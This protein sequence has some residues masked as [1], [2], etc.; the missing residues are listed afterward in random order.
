VLTNA[1][2]KNTF[3]HTLHLRVKKILEG[4][5]KAPEWW[6]V[7][8]GAP[9]DADIFDLKVQKAC[10]PA[11]NPRLAASMEIDAREVKQVPSSENEFRRLR[12]GQWVGSS[13]AWVAATIVEKCNLHRIRYD[14]LKG[15]V[16]YGG[17][18]LAYSQ[19]FNA[20][21]LLIPPLKSELV[22]V[23][24]EEQKKDILVRK[25]YPTKKDPFYWLPTFWIPEASV[26]KRKNQE[27]LDVIQWI[28]DG[29]I[30]VTPGFT[31]DDDWIA[32]DILQMHKD[33]DI[34]LNGVDAYRAEGVIKQLIRD[35]M[36]AEPY[37]QGPLTMGVPVDR[38]EILFVNGHI[39]HGGHPMVIW[40]MDNAHVYTDRN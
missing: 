22:Q 2:K 19:D 17:L 23:F 32:A 8:H 36:P 14:K 6:V 35:G 11:W 30:K 18:D 3:P 12:L 39:N 15:R 38:V 40:Q 28:D 9:E 33:F 21:S 31:R 10:N 37:R 16:A 34:K 27:H 29:L 7:I 26:E 13:I 4:K 5:L 1:G 20:H 24:D 25:Y